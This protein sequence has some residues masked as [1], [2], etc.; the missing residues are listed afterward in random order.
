MHSSTPLYRTWPHPFIS[1]D[2]N[3]MLFIS[4]PLSLERPTSLDVVILI[5]PI[6]RTYV[7]Y[8]NKNHYWLKKHVESKHL[9]TQLVH[10]FT[11]LRTK[12]LKRGSVSINIPLYLFLL[13][14][15]E[16][17]KS[18]YVTA[19]TN[20]KF[21]RKST[22]TCFKILSL[23]ATERNVNNWL[24]YLRHWVQISHL[25]YDLWTSQL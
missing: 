11:E 5:S 10:I 4:A 25:R 17:S 20:H 3:F 1:S 2:Y 7:E 9:S 24:I 18:K 22:V 21:G 6:T 12:T 15:F 14:F 23:L 8:Q 19:I 16:H 13:N